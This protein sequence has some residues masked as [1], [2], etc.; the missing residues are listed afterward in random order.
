MNNQ[1]LKNYLLHLLPAFILPLGLHLFDNSI[2][3]VN[4]LKVGLIFPVLTLAFKGLTVYFPSANLKNRSIARTVEYAIL[5][6][7]VFAAFV[8]VTTG[9]VE[10]GLQSSLPMTLRQFMIAVSVMSIFN[11]VAGLSQQKKLR[12]S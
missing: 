5:Q 4:L 6:G 9:F 8:V 12:N 10:P 3:L 2:P 11:F 7:F 1:I